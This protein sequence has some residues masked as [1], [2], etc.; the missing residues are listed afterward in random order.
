MTDTVRAKVLW[1]LIL[2]HRPEPSPGSATAAAVAALAAEGRA[3][4][5]GGRVRLAPHARA[6]RWTE[7]AENKINVAARLILLTLETTGGPIRSCRRLGAG[8]GIAVEHVDEARQRLIADG[9]IRITADNAT[10]AA[11]AV[12]PTPG[13]TPE[14]LGLTRV[15][16]PAPSPK[17]ATGELPPPSERAP[18]PAPEQK[19]GLSRPPMRAAVPPAPNPVAPTGASAPAPPPEQDL[20]IR[21]L[22]GVRTEAA[23][24]VELLR[25]ERNLESLTAWARDVASGTNAVGRRHGP[26]FTAAQVRQYARTHSFRARLSRAQD[27]TVLSWGFTVGPAGPA[28]RFQTLFQ[29]WFQGWFQPSRQT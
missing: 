22:V 17:S 4:R 11:V 24:A 16:R 9:L 18:A 23:A 7:T 29:S 28:G 27:R 21:T 6:N 19:P 5:D 12:A 3:V 10:V 1:Q 20:P 13:L 14:G 26:R 15:R 2:D 25:F 8:Y